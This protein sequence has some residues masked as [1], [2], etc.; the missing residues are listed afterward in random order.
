M[1]YLRPLYEPQIVDIEIENGAAG[2]APKAYKNP[3]NKI[4]LTEKKILKRN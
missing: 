4:R 3:D 1:S 2:A